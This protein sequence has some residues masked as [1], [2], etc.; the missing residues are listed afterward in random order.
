MAPFTANHTAFRERWPALAAEHRWRSVTVHPFVLS[1]NLPPLEQI[2]SVNMVPFQHDRALI[3]VMDNGGILLPGGTRERGETLGET[4]AREMDEEL[5]AVVRSSRLLGYWPCHSGDPE[6]WRPHLSHPDFLRVV[7]YGEVER[8]RR[9]TN[10]DDGEPIAMIKALAA[11]DAVRWLRI[12]NRPE[13][14]DIYDLA[15]TMRSG[16]IPG[17]SA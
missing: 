8:V 6:P 12:C 7:Y 2:Q 3:P 14:A 17:R 5:G 15:A 11:D 9:P 16:H 13:L 1:T 4:L 10:P